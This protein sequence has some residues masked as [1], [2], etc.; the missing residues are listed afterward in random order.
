MKTQDSLFGLIAR[1]R[2]EGVEYVLV[3]GQA[4]QL[5]GFFACNRNY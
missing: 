4:V 3:G 1:L 5:N 2:D